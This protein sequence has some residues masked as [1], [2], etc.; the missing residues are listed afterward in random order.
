[1]LYG[2]E[3][4]CLG[5]NEIGILKRTERAMVRNM[6]GAKLMDNKMTKDPMQMLHLNETIDQLA[7]ANN[8]R[9]YGNVLRKDKNNFLRRALDCKV[10]GTRK[11][12][13]QRKPG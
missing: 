12:G 1:M 2:S 7:K 13:D 11:R 4:W 6:C 10:K 8:V 9:W 3:T 5:Q